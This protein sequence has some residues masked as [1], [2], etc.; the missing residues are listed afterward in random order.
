MN[1]E[2]MIYSHDNSNYDIAIGITDSEKATLSEKLGSIG[3][4]FGAGITTLSQV[5]ELVE[6][7]MSKKELLFLTSM[8]IKGIVQSHSV[9]C[10]KEDDEPE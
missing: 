9:E 4:S 3:A 2:I 5:T 6:I 7:S 10:R 8:Y 1:E